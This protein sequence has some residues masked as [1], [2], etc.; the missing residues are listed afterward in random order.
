MSVT[1]ARGF[2]TA[3]VKAGLKASG[4]LD[5]A[6]VQNV[7][8]VFSAA[9]TFTP[10]RAAAAPILVSRDA[11]KSSGGVAQ[12]VIV[13]SGSANACTG[14]PGVARA[15]ETAQALSDALGIENVNQVQVCSTGKIGVGLDM[16]KMLAGIELAVEALE[17]EETSTSEQAGID[18]SN[19][20]CTTD[21]R[22]KRAQLESA[23]GYR[24]GGM[25]KGA[26]MIAP[27]MAT[28]ICVVTTDVEVSPKLLQKIVSR[29]VELSFNRIDSDGCMST[30]DTV[31]VLANG[32]S[33]VKIDEAADEAVFLE[34]LTTVMKELAAQIISDA[35]GATHDILIKV[36]NATSEEAA[37]A[38]AREIS[39]SNLLKCA[40]FGGDPNW[41]RVLAAMGV[42]PEK[43]APFDM[44][45]VDVKMNGVMVCRDGAIGDDSKLVDLKT[46][47]LITIDVDLKACQGAQARSAEL[48]TN[49]LT[50][51]YVEINAEYST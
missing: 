40:L 32:A 48:L 8:P 10:S 49:D 31:V 29:S 12:A 50:Y 25:V 41:G 45:K 30:N 18:A 5:M 19:A 20:I 13:N 23:S 51:E 39:R 7:G 17:D 44:N 33:G 2:R 6:V 28:M 22:P 35:E 27:G 16:P 9:A 14:E 3:G 47:R 37:V 42:V 36:R 21:S 24:I 11:L 43:I 38:V 26:G 34:N 1:F 46:E 4:N 15:K